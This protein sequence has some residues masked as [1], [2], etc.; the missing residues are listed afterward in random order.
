LG[1]LFDMCRDATTRLESKHA[2][3]MALLR[4]KGELA[5]KAGFLVALVA[6]SDPDDPEKMRRLH[7]AALEIGIDI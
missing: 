1:A 2:E 7:M 5:S 3:P 4:A 6:Q